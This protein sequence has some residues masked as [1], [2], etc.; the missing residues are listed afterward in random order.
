MHL[1]LAFFGE[2]GLVVGAV[3]A[4]GNLCY[5]WST[6]S[7][8]K[9]VELESR[10]FPIVLTESPRMIL[11][12]RV[13][14]VLVF[15]AGPLCWLVLPR[16]AISEIRTDVASTVVSAM[17]IGL[18]ILVS[19]EEKQFLVLN[20]QSFTY[21]KTRKK[22]ITV[23]A[24]EITGFTA[25]NGFLAISLYNRPK[26]LVIRLEIWKDSAYLHELLTRWQKEQVEQQA[27]S[28]SL[29]R[30]IPGFGFSQEN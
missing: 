28:E 23:R 19:R 24:T 10:S 26:R 9:K 13:L 27:R 6:R 29:P 30:P 25:R 21:N 4:T 5:W 22:S 3:Y 15:L 7:F 12:G 2:G 16:G 8:N 17:G 14:A 1:D 11:L 20:E 18:W